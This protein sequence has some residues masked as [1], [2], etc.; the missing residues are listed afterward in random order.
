MPTQSTDLDELELSGWN[1]IRKALEEVEEIRKNGLDARVEVVDCRNPAGV[2]VTLRSFRELQEFI[3][4]RFS[5]M[6]ISGF[7]STIP[8]DDFERLVAETST[9]LLDDS[10]NIRGRFLEC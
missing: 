3:S 10:D 6:L 8:L 1:E 4:Y 7:T 5:R 9:D 2:R